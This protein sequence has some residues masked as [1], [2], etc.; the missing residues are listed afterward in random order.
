M[1]TSSVFEA[2]PISMGS[3]ASLL[4]K[5]AGQ[6][7]SFSLRAVSGRGLSDA[8]V[9]FEREAS[10]ALAAVA[11]ILETQSQQIWSG[12]SIVERLQANLSSAFG[13]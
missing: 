4:E 5:T 2:A 6:A 7:A 12:A 13:R 11:L 8:Q 9:Q 10:D 1:S 3:V